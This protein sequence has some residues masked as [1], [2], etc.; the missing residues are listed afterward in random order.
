[1]GK[2]GLGAYSILA[3]VFLLI[4][5][6]YTIVFS[7]NDVRRTNIV[8]R[9]FTFDN[10]LNI[11]DQPEVCVAFGNSILVGGA[12]TI[13]AT[14]LGT[15][16]AIALVRYRF[17]FRAAT[18]LLLFLPMATP[19][20]VLGAGLAAQFL[21]AGIPKGLLTII[22]AHTMF[23]I[24][25]VVVTVRARV[26]SLDPALEEAG[27]DLYA[28]PGQVFWRITFPLLLPG[29]IAAALLSFAL[30]FDDFII[31]NFNSG[32]AVTF[33]K[34]VYTAAARGIPAQANVIASA[35]FFAAI[36][37][38]VVSQL[39]AAARRKKLAKSG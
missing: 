8:W 22:I 7:F 18:T 39:S 5:I 11:C 33:P 27:R 30:S 34:Y 38:V 29:I 37:L 15:A 26:A 28:S 21:S 31:T 24:S 1:M 36:V 32:A 25:F 9:G 10:W 2:W 13:A 4:P 19:E 14:T 6:A 16:M 23:C 17:K 20:V 3:L 12:A 35:V